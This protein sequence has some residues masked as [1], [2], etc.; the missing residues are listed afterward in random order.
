M[1]IGKNERTIDV[2]NRK[3][4][5]DTLIVGQSIAR[6]LS[7]AQRRRLHFQ[8]R[9]QLPEHSCHS[10]KWNYDEG[11][12]KKFLGH[13]LFQRE[14]HKQSLIYPFQ[15]KNNKTQRKQQTNFQS[16]FQQHLN[17]SSA[18]SPVAVSLA[19]SVARSLSVPANIHYWKPRDSSE[20][21]GSLTWWRV[22][23]LFAATNCG[24][25]RPYFN[26]RQR[27]EETHETVLST[28]YRFWII[29]FF[30]FSLF[31]SATPK[32]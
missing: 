18:L 7:R 2:N 22:C 5:I 10:G 19:I 20:A 15:G 23:H 27:A 1:R 21:T 28:S 4:R 3:H 24:T 6:S 12:R 14:W 32:I 17:L 26:P 9:F 8:S 25:V 31:F 29:N 30:M 16:H 11:K 13:V